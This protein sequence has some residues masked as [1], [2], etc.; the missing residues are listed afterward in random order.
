MR[1]HADVAGDGPDLVLLHGWG[2]HAGV[3]DGVREP[4]GRRFRVHALDL[5]GHG[6][7]RTIAFG[8]LDSVCDAVEAAMPREAIVCGWSMGGLIAQHLAARG[9]GRVRALALVSTTPCFVERPDWPHAMK[10]TTLEAF[11]QGLERDPEATLR[12]FVVLNALGGSARARAL[13]RTL[14]AGLAA[15]GAPHAT[16]LVHGLTL[17][18]DTDLRA[19]SARLALPCVVIHGRRDVLAPVAAGE[20]LAARVPGA[21][22]EA[23][24]R[25]RP[26]ALPHAPR[27]LRRGTG[28]AS[29]LSARS[30][31]A[32][33][34]APSSARPRV[35]TRPPSC[36]AKWARASSSTSIP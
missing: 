29:W 20:W 15:R 26:L 30:S 35:T 13:A 16:A 7:S 31:R 25:R 8:D 11:A 6:H 19:A 2:L 24:G 14:A 34:A 4:L 22:L 28:I 23:Q 10:L 1:L 21:R 32:R 36:S 3:W 9:T 27:C 12:T 17:L 5:P 18:R 33:C